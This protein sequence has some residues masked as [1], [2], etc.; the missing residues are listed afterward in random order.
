MTGVVDHGQGH[1]LV[2]SDIGATPCV[3]FSVTNSYMSGHVINAVHYL[4]RDVV[5]ALHLIEQVPHGV[6]VDNDQG[7]ETASVRHAED[8]IVNSLLWMLFIN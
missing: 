4:G 3:L 1:I 7:G 2:A 6:V 5:V 8:G